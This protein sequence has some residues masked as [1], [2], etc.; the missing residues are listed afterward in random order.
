MVSSPISFGLSL[1]IANKVISMSEN[2]DS[3]SIFYNKFR[4]LVSYKTTR[5][6]LMSKARFMKCMEFQRLYEMERPDANTAVPA[7]YELY[8][9]SHI[10]SAILNSNASEQ[11]SRMIAMDGANKN[12]GELNKKLTL[13]Y[14]KARQSQITT[15]L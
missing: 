11:S 15:E 2:L 8:I 3:I 7:L 6:E 12:C 4:N 1:A 13:L 9:A 14:N 5:T 10:H